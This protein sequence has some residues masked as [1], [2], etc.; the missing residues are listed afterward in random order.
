MV[1]AE[2]GDAPPRIARAALDDASTRPARS[3]PFPET[4]G[5]PEPAGGAPS[6]AIRGNRER[7]ASVQVQRWMPDR[8]P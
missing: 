5:F 2:G 8:R 1:P 7:R 6:T 4:A 3:H